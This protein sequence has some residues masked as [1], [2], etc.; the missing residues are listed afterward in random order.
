MRA[1]EELLEDDELVGGVYDAQAAPANL[2]GHVPRNVRALHVA[3]GAPAQVVE[4]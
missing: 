3:N 2:D 4:A 1:V